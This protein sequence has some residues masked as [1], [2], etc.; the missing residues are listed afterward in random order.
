MALFTSFLRNQIVIAT[1]P[2]SVDWL[3]PAQKDRGM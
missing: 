3:T 2:L 1:W